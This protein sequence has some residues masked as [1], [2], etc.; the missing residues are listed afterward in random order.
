MR[1]DKKQ[2]TVFGD[3][4]CY[5]LMDRS[6]VNILFDHQ[7]FL[8]EYYLVLRLILYQITSTNEKLP[9]PVKGSSDM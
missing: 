1:H 4:I 9:L 3:K 7:L 5:N 6:T 2:R 8:K